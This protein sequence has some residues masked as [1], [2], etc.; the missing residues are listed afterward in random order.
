M[1]HIPTK[2]ALLAWIDENPTLTAKRDIAKAFGIKGSSARIALK[3]MLRDLASEGAVVKKRRTFS[4][5][6]KLPPVSVF[7]LLGQMRRVIFSQ[8]LPNGQ[9]KAPHRAS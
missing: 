2:A 5:V 8:A 7:R 6:A 4:D 3:A 1:D 9:E